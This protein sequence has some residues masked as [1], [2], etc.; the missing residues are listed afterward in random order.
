MQPQLVSRIQAPEGPVTYEFRPKVAGQ[1]PLTGDQL[2][3]LQEAMH[4]VTREPNGTARNRFRGMSIPIAGKTGTAETAVA[5]PDAWFAGYTFANRPDR[6]DIAVA[7]WVSN[8]GQ[9][10]D[11][12]APIFRRVIEAYFGL[13]YLRY[14]WEEAVGVPATPEPT[15][16]EGGEATAAPP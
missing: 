4:N 10:S 5:E 12:A 2:A 15:P 16:T 1:L 8:R 13:S 9:G 3:A 14:P 6:P 7:V 11:V